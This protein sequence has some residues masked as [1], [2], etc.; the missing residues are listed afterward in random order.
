MNNTTIVAMKINACQNIKTIY[1]IPDKETVGR[2]GLKD[3]F[4]TA[5]SHKMRFLVTM[6]V[7]HPVEASMTDWLVASYSRMS[8]FLQAILAPS[9]DKK[10]N[11][12]V[13]LCSI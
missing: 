9:H 3:C 10:K 7:E 8:V 5:F 1:Y 13:L 2:E 4:S 12:L 11:M 6:T